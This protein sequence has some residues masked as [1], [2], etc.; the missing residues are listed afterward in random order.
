MRPRAVQQG[1]A[2][3]PH[4]G[5]RKSN[6]RLAVVLASVALAFALCFVAKIWLLGP[7]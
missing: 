2:M 4:A 3:A 5:R 7:Y 1:R 6:L